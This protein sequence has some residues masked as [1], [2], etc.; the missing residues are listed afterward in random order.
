MDSFGWDYSYL[1]AYE[2]NGIK[3]YSKTGVPVH[4]DRLSGDT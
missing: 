4:T 3:V 1:P 2:E